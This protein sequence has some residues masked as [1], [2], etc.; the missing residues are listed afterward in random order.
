MLGG[1]IR[2]GALALFFLLSAGAQDSA[3]SASSR[4]VEFS[5]DVEPI[6]KRCQGCHGASVQMNGLRLDARDGALAGGA[7]GPAITPGDGAASRLIRVVSGADKLV[8]P[9]AGPKLTSAEVD[10]LRTWIDQGAIWRES[11]TPTPS[12]RP[13]LESKHWSFE[14][15]GDYA[16]PETINRRWAR[17][18]IDRFVLARLER[19]GLL[20]SE[21]AS[22]EVLIRRLI[23][24]LKQR[25][26]LDTTLIVWGGEFGRT[27]M[28]EM[29]ISS[30]AA[31]AGRDHHPNGFSM[32]LA[33]GGI[34]GGQVIGKTDDLGLSV[35]EEKV[36]VHD[37][38]ATILHCLGLDHT[39]LTYR[40]MGRNF[41]L[42]DVE[43]E[44]VGKM[45]S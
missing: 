39:K 1:F 9:P 41:R 7:S 22:R 27:P 3:K 16:P 20:P 44:V 37:L 24:D 35:A 42:T 31:S 36:H 14:P 8:M 10:L 15:I 34:K 25:G 33:G 4:T 38:Q 29:R 43:G 23:R 5:R 13:A 45:I 21:E 6:L 11:A 19:A 28:S 12:T 17:N 2:L 30:D 32:W 26:L 18:P 40:H